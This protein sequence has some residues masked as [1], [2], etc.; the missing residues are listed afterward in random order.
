MELDVAFGEKTM[1][2]PVYIKMYRCGV[3]GFATVRLISPRSLRCELTWL[4][5]HLSNRPL[6]KC[7]LS[8]SEVITGNL[9]STSGR[10]PFCAP[11]MKCHLRT[12]C[13]SRT[14]LDLLV[15]ISN[16]TAM[17]QLLTKGACVGEVTSVTRMDPS[18]YRESGALLVN[19]KQ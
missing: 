14:K 4:R 11:N 15:V 19:H 6:C 3:D 1:R 8:H 12:Y 2:T 5:F 17:P 16:P 7:R 10:Q 9:P 13:C 18:E